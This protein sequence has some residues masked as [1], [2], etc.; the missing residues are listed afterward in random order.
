MGSHH[1]MESEDPTPGTRQ[2]R[3]QIKRR[4]L[5]KCVVEGCDSPT[6]GYRCEAHAEE[7]KQ[8]ER[9]RRHGEK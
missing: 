2:R 3:H 6:E 4:Q 8:R 9:K 5:G 7:H 1:P